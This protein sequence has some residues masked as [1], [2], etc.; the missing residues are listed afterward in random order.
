MWV[1]MDDERGLIEGKLG[2][3]KLNIRVGVG[4]E[5]L[6]SSG[7]RSFIPVHIFVWCRAERCLHESVVDANGGFPTPRTSVI[8]TV[9]HHG[10]SQLY[11]PGAIISHG[12]A[13]FVA[14]RA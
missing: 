11:F 6:Q 8:F 1:L 7:A 13:T 3:S 9:E 12:S 4:I 10:E 2:N 5:R 14:P